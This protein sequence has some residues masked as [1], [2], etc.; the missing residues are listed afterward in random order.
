MLKISKSTESTIQPEEGGVGFDGN[1]RAGRNDRCKLNGSKIGDSE[2]N[3]S[4]VKDNEVGKKGQKMSE[5][6]KLFK[7]KKMIGS[8]FLIL[9]ARLAFTKLKQTFVKAPIFYHFDP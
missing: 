6:K 8:D 1:T 5:S 9:R 2:V 7:S 3:D 4:E